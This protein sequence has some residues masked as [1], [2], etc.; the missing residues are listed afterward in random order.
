MSAHEC[1]ALSHWCNFTVSVKLYLHEAEGYSGEVE[2][3][4]G[5][6]TVG[7]N[8]VTFHPRRAIRVGGRYIALVRRGKS[9]KTRKHV[10]S[11]GEAACHFSR[12]AR[13]GQTDCWK[14]VGARAAILPTGHSPGCVTSMQLLQTHALPTTYDGDLYL[15][16]SKAAA[17]INTTL[18]VAK[19]KPL[20]GQSV[21]ST[22]AGEKSCGGNADAHYYT[23]LNKI[24]L[25]TT[26]SSGEIWAA[27]NSEVLRTDVHIGNPRENP[28]T[29]D[30]IR[31]DPHLKKS[32]NDPTGIENQFPYLDGKRQWLGETA[33]S[34]ENPPVAGNVRNDYP[35]GIE[36]GSPRWK[37]GSITTTP[38]HSQ[39]LQVGATKLFD[40]TKP[41]S[42]CNNKH[43]GVKSESQVRD[44]VRTSCRC[45]ITTARFPF[46]SPPRDSQQ[47]AN[48]ATRIFYHFFSSLPDKTI[49]VATPAHAELYYG[50]LGRPASLIGFAKTARKGT[51]KLQCRNCNYESCSSGPV[52]KC[53]G[54]QRKTRELLWASPYTRCI[55]TSSAGVT[56]D[57]FSDQLQERTHLQQPRPFPR[58]PRIRC[59]VLWCDFLYLGQ[60]SLHK[61]EEYPRSRTLAG[62]QKSVAQQCMDYN[63]TFCKKSHTVRRQKQT[64]RF[65]ARS[66][67]LFLMRDNIGWGS[68][69]GAF[70]STAIEF[71]RCC[72]LIDCY[73]G[74]LVSLQPKFSA[75]MCIILRSGRPLNASCKGLRKWKSRS[76][77]VHSL[78]HKLA[79]VLVYHLVGRLPEQFREH[80]E[81]KDRPRF[82]HNSFAPEQ[83][84]LWSSAGMEKAGE[85]VDPRENPPTNGI[86]RHD[87]HVRKSGCKNTR[88]PSP[89]EYMTR[90]TD[91]LINFAT[92]S[93]LIQRS[94]ALLVIGAIALAEAKRNLS[95]EGACS[96]LSALRLELDL[97]KFRSEDLSL[98]DEL[99][100]GRPQ[101]L[102][103][104]AL[105]AAIDD[106]SQT[107]WHRSALI[108]D[109]VLTTDEKCVLYDT[110]KL[111]RHWLSPRDCVPYTARPPP[112]P[113]QTVH[114]ELLPA[115]NTVTQTE[116]LLVNR[117]CVLVLHDN[118]R[119]HVARVAKDAIQVGWTPASKVKKLGSDTGD[120]NTN[121][122]FFITQ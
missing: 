36:P 69:R 56:P 90:F 111:A 46:P 73:Y 76:T 116:P 63:N 24:Y 52:K 91:V 26:K 97:S 94:T 49:R 105:E 83:Y 61:A 72:I 23:K 54:V 100:S 21:H 112:H 95:A 81:L 43:Q 13:V 78:Y 22:A 104:D 45:I 32:G 119:P 107:K 37:A 96:G 115:R 12:E 1:G 60:L 15:I 31:H 118:A 85:M 20:A 17:E 89:I 101:V 62:I 27:H 102:D 120:T 98:W 66:S 2:L 67:P 92:G 58:K 88:S 114:H 16:S 70:D 8:P 4:Q 47:L 57:M 117:I 50:K 14:E 55:S 29:S 75:D 121:F 11:A 34:G 51:H 93:A 38:P 110:P 44:D 86:V 25:L 80:K 77:T 3:Y 74:K 39:M 113:R 35:L 42:Q 40:S 79:Q 9:G 122:Y 53:D 28:L 33:I 64:S 108:F 65:S 7:S 106:S 48:L 87:S 18:P 5:F 19:S 99:R 68:Y 59:G 82:E 10:A 30:I 41:F 109:R 84:A 71:R 103:H 6:R